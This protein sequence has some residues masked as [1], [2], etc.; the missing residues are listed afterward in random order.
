MAGCR[1]AHSIV[2]YEAVSWSHGSIIC[3]PIDS[4]DAVHSR[5]P[6]RKDL[7]YH[8]QYV[9]CP[10]MPV[11]MLH[12]TKTWM[13]GRIVVAWHRIYLPL[14]SV[15]ADQCVPACLG[16]LRT[17]LPLQA[18]EWKHQGC[19]PFLLDNVY[20]HILCHCS[21]IKYRRILSGWILFE[22]LHTAWSHGVPT[23]N[24]NVRM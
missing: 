5:R 9:R 7:G 24:P 3:V 1:D 22:C 16:S 19:G 10:T 13:E 23:Q 12:H 6:T 14:Q 8:I 11:L 18:F 20:K 2:L 15:G 21:W 4:I 17:R